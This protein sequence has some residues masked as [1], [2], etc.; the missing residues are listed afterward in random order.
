MASSASPSVVP[1]SIGDVFTKSA[2]RGAQS[3]G[4]SLDALLAA[5]AFGFAIFGAQLALF[6]LLNSRL[7]RI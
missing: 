5:S 1:T 4:Q 7:S 2:G 3:S 6:I